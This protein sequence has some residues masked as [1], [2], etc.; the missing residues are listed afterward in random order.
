MLRGSQEIETLKHF[1]TKL[2][3]PQKM[4]VFSLTIYLWSYQTFFLV[5]LNTIS[6]T[7]MAT[8]YCR[9]KAKWFVSHHFNN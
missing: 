7:L 1:G 9:I 8:F 6:V 4:R 5:A 2:I 3:L